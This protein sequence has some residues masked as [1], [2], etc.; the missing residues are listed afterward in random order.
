M[1]QNSL[2]MASKNAILKSLLVSI[3]K[4]FIYLSS[5]AN[6]VKDELEFQGA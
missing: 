2:C 1:A 4:V 6:L 3:C 5:P